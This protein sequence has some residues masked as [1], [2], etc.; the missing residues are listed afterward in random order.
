MLNERLMIGVAA[1]VI[2]AAFTIGIKKRLSES[3]RWL[4][5]STPLLTTLMIIFYTVYVVEPSHGMGI[6]I[7][8]ITTS[9]I[10]LRRMR[11]G[12]PNLSAGLFILLQIGFTA[13]YIVTVWLQ[14]H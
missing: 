13:L 1:A 5:I 6:M 11:S 3:W 12:K 7:L 4:L 10:C 9:W 14:E 2:T 8:P